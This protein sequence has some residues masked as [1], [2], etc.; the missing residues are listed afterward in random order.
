MNKSNSAQLEKM[1]TTPVGRLVVTLG[2]P[3]T[4]SMLVTNIYNIA[5]TYFVSR[6]GISASGAVGIVFGFM[7]VLQ[8][9]GFMFGQGAGSNISRHLGAGDEKS[10]SQYATL[11]FVSAFVL[12]VV[13]GI[14]CLIFLKPFL[15]L[16]GSTET[17]LPYAATYVTFIIIASPFTVCGFVM[18][19]IL[20]FEGKANLAM[21]GLVFG[22]LL[23]IIGDPILIFGFGLGIAGAGI[24]TAVS[25]IISFFILLSFFVRG[26][27]SSK[28]K[29]S[30]F[31]P[32]FSKLRDIITIGFP[33]MARQGLQ[34]ISTMFL[35]NYAALYGDAAVAAMSIVSRIT[36]LIFA[37]GLGIGQGY[38]PVCG[39]NYGAGKYSRV[40]EAFR[41]TLILSQILLGALAVICIFIAPYAVG[42]FRKDPEVLEIGVLALRLQCAG[43]FF[44][45]LGVMANMTFQGSGKAL[46]AVFSSM[47]RS[48]LFFIPTI[49]IGAGLFG[50]LGVQ[51]AQPVSD[52][53]TFVTMLPMTVYYMKKLPE[54]K[55]TV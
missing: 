36:F 33:S 18:N 34:S 6:I 20:R 53:L 9:I 5:D 31:K 43:L 16:L 46:A 8:A 7:S 15:R 47:L 42:W 48:G 50:I 4:I 26:K 38:Q 12:S 17:I 14:I 54:D 28:L 37:V 27:T 3:T 2:I 44:Q 45:P 22:A 19:N 11:S 39:F 1:T 30:H 52:I 40:K 24:S 55:E 32:D 29:I 21:I 49:V 13:I 41:F 25:Q 51:S 10:A 23:N 35:N